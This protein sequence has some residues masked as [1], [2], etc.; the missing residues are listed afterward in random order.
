VLKLIGLIIAIVAIGSVVYLAVNN[1]S[2]VSAMTESISAEINEFTSPLTA[3]PDVI[4]PLVGGSDRIDKLEAKV[5]ELEA[6]IA[7]LNGEQPQPVR[8]SEIIIPNITQPEYCDLRWSCVQPY[9]IIIQEGD[10]VTWENQEDHQIRI[11]HTANTNGCGG[12]TSSLISLTIDAGQIAIQKFTKA[13]VFN[14]CANSHDD[15]HIFGTITV[16]KVS[17][18]GI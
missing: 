3:T 4:L 10:T 16:E 1:E 9:Y 13:G 5:S 11:A 6:K 2:Q 8:T 17:N 12:S 7:T 18:S 14:W 15:R